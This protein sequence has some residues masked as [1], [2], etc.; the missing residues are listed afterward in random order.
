MVISCGTTDSEELVPSTVKSSSLRYLRNFHKLKPDRRAMKPRTI[1]TNMKQV[2]YMVATSLP[3]DTIEPRPYLPT[4]KAIAPQAAS[5]ATR[6]I[7]PTMWNMPWE[8]DSSTS[9]MG[10]PRG[11]KCAKAIPNKVE[12]SRIGR[13]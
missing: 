7:M 12:N 6:M 5:G 8:N 2:R 1:T 9:T 3:R 13:I 11:P 10:F 4:V